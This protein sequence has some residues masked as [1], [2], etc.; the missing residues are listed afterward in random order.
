MTS[1]IKPANF[2][3]RAE[4][5]ASKIHRQRDT[6]VKRMDGEDVWEGMNQFAA[7]HWSDAQFDRFNS[8]MNSR[9]PDVVRKAL[10]E[11]RTDY[12]K[13]MFGGRQG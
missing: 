2:N 3:H 11:L 1:Y 5:E 12:S 9:D 7:D 13:A 8:A 4:A 6:F 10:N